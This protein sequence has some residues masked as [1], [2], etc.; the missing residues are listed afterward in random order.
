MSRVGSVVEVAGEPSSLDKKPELSLIDWLGGR[1]YIGQCS[2]T[3]GQSS[4][5]GE[6]VL[7]I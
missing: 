7:L 4:K 3:Q 2:R 5:S 6:N 1:S